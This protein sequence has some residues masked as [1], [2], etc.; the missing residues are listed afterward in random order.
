MDRV[1]QRR[2]AEKFLALHEAPDILVLPNAWDV[3]SAKI[4]EIEGFKALGTTSAGISAV[5]GY[6]DGQRISLNEMA[7]AVARIVRHTDLPVNADMEAGYARS[8]EG[9]AASARIMLE[10]GAVGINLEDGTGDPSAPLLDPIHQKDKI[11]AIR[12]VAAS[13]GVPLVLNVRIDVYLASQESSDARLRNTLQ[14]ARIY[15]EAGA[16]CIFVPSPLDEPG[17]LDHETLVN[18]VRGID[19]PLNVL[20]GAVTLP[21][22]E[23]EEIGVARVSLGP[24]PMRAAFALVRKIARELQDQG[25]YTHITKDTIPYFEV[26]QWFA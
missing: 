19:A 3:S 21:L 2:K 25:T 1:T 23:L 17:L 4:F 16:D 9:A 26:N 14:R 8:A 24:G 15:R 12:E 7:E 22:A 18:L 13:E 5:L 10:T 11:Q 6:P 20:A